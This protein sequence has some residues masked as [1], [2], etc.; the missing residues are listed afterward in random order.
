MKLRY[1]EFTGGVYR[2]G[3]IVGEISQAGSPPMLTYVHYQL[4][5]HKLYAPSL[6]LL[7]PMVRD[8]LTKAVAPVPL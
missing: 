5:R 1:D 3:A 6:E 4:P 7:L 8:L 2:N